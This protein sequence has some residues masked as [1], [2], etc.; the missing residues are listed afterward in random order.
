MKINSIDIKSFRGIDT[1]HHD[2]TKPVTVLTGKVGAGKTSFIQALQFALTNDTPANPIRLGEKAA[3]V[4]LSCEDDITIEREVAA[5]NKKSIKVMGRKTGTSA[6]ESFLEESTKV[7]TDIMRIATSSEVLASMKPSQFGSIFLNESVERKTLE[8]L[9]KI[10]TNCTLKEKK[11][12]MADTEDEDEED[13]EKKLPADVL[14][15]IKSLFREKTF[16]L[17]GINKAFEEAKTIRRTRNADLKLSAA[18]SKDF[19][20]IVKPEYTEKDLNKKLEEI[21]GVEKNVEAYKTQVAAYKKAKEAKNEQDKRIAELEIN[22]AMN[23]SEKPDPTALAKYKAEREAASND[24]VEN[25]KVLQTLLN[26]KEWFERTLAELDKPV[27]PISE[28]L[29]CKTDK[30]SFKNDLMD[31]IEKQSLSIAVME[32]KVKIAQNKVTLADAKITT[33]NKNREEWNKKVMLQNE[34]DRLKAKPVEL[35]EEPEKVS[36]K[37]SYAAEKAEIKEKLNT[38]AEYNAAEAEY[39]RTREL[40]RKVAI[41]DFIVKALDP[42]GPVIKEFISTF[43]DCLEDACNERADMLKTG[44]SVKFVPE[45]GLTVLF[46]TGS[47]KE[48][49]PYIS[50]SAGEKILASLILTDL[51]NSFYDSRILILDDTDHLDADAFKMLMDFVSTSDITDLYDNIIISCVEHSDMLEVAKEYDVDLL[52]L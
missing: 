18:K 14:S 47:S 42:K 9:I 26:G 38:L 27:C 44:F 2:F 36:L 25:S 22:I 35:P 40:K 34:L 29:V 37:S 6:S 10:L 30:T 24:V 19:L 43:V 17:E 32:D 5:P 39:K 28:K 7:S 11:A 45:D 3:N 8:D 52:K 15:E 33:Y 13:E 20:D 4:L 23:R 48:Y 49:L 31:T 12:V 1:L 16:S 21:I 46:K 51:I 41:S 50:L